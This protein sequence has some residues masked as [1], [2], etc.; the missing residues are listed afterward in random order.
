[1][2]SSLGVVI[3]FNVGIAHGESFP[4]SNFC[5]T[6]DEAVGKLHC[7]FKNAIAINNK[8]EQPGVGEKQSVV[9]PGLSIRRDALF[10]ILNN[11]LTLAS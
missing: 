8:C 5:R 7:R 4:W 10:E 6:I 11:R 3:R 9:E 1:M 2:V